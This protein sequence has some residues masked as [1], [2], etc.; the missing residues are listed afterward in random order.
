ML[1]NE[2]MEWEAQGRAEGGERGD[3]PEHPRNE[4]TKIKMLWLDAFSYCNATN[5]CFMYLIF[6]NLF[7]VNTSF[8]VLQMPV[9]L[10]FLNIGV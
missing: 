5:T 6:R 10:I 8:Y 2:L 7:L 9:F 1:D 3:G 4:I